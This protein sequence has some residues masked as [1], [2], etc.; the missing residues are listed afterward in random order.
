MEVQETGS[1]AMPA[2]SMLNE[3]KLS[4]KVKTVTLQPSWLVLM[5]PV[6]GPQTTPNSS[7]GLV[8]YL[9]YLLE[10]NKIFAFFPFPYHVKAAQNLCASLPVSKYNK[11]QGQ[12]AKQMP[13]YFKS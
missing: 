13:E 2:G 10:P 7:A 6:R 3:E 11:D 5:M 9:F 4:K 1:K 8:G 12:R